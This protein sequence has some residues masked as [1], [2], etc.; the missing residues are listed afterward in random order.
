MSKNSKN[1]PSVDQK[2]KKNFL[3]LHKIFCTGVGEKWSKWVPD[4]NLVVN[5]GFAIGVIFLFAKIGKKRARRCEK[6]IIW[7][8]VIGKS[9]LITFYVNYNRA[10]VYQK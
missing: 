7:L 6:V 1:R 10:F 2:M 3:H 9:F 4:S 8:N 5:S